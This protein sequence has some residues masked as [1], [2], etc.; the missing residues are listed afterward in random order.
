MGKRKISVT[1]NGKEEVFEVECEDDVV[2]E[3]FS[4]E[5]KKKK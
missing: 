5:L 4:F 3:D 2:I 1:I